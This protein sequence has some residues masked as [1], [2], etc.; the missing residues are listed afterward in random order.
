TSQDVVDAINNQTEDVVA[1]IGTGGEI[2]LTS[3]HSGTASSVKVVPGSTGKDLKAL[4]GLADFVQ[5]TETTAT[6]AT[7]LN[8]LTVNLADYANGDIVQV[9]GTDK[10]GTPVVAS[11]VY[12]TDGTTLGDLVG[13]LESKFG[14]S[15][16]AFDPATGEISVK[17]DTTGD[18]Q[19]SL[20]LTDGP[21]QAGRSS[22]SS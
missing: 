5:G 9:A 20:A 13:F 12:G 15:T 10:D 16:V 14:Q 3:E 18:A 2:V 7:D 22:W 17:A 11:F 4:L 6:D 8:D 1:S 21:G 19:L